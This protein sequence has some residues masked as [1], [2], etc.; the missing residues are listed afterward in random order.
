[1]PSNT[2]P[3]LEAGGGRTK[4]K[5][6]T[7]SGQ[8][9]KTF[10]V[11]DAHG[12]PLKKYSSKEAR[13]APP[14]A[15]ARKLAKH[16]VG[17]KSG[18]H[19][20][21]VRAKG[22]H[23]K[24][25][26]GS[27]KVFGYTVKRVM[28]DVSPWKIEQSEIHGYI[29]SATGRQYEEGDKMPAYDVKAKKKA[30]SAKKKSAKKKSAKKKSAKKSA[31]STKRKHSG[32]KKSKK[33]KSAKRLRGGGGAAS[34]LDEEDSTQRV[35]KKILRAS[36]NSGPDKKNETQCKAC[37]A[38]LIGQDSE[39]NKIVQTYVVLIAKKLQTKGGKMEV[40]EGEK[41]TL[42]Y[43]SGEEEETQTELATQIAA[44]YA[45]AK[46]GTGEGDDDHIV[47]TD[48]DLKDNPVVLQSVL[49]EAKAAVKAAE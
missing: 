33:K 35:A 6:T 17:K 16:V 10:F 41:T 30:K 31:K 12:S 8:V 18:A 23:G 49:E 45:K 15:A 29:N 43:K 44:A 25:S 36:M 39:S 5:T 37:E 40:T 48:E 20:I 42:S 19:T 4:R 32:A 27:P 28:V 11:C 24:Y 1:M 9:I 22:P 46:V 3:A 7:A 21:F 34:L 2:T 13:N 47:S 26:D 38:L 14:S